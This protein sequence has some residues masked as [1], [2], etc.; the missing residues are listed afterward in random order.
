MFLGASIIKNEPIPELAN[1]EVAGSV[2]KQVVSIADKYYQ[3]GKFTTFAAYEWTSTPD[4]R[5]MHRNIIF[6]DSKKVPDIPFLPW[7]RIILRISGTGWIRSAKQAMSCWRSRIT[8][9]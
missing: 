5:N 3:P 4:N 7:T 9:T 1:P 2:W 6:K 8:P